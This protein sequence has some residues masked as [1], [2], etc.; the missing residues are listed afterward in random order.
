MSRTR[1]ATVIVLLVGGWMTAAHPRSAQ[2]QYSPPVT[3]NLPQVGGGPIGD[4]GRHIPE[5][6]PYGREIE[7]KQLK[8]LRQEHQRELKDDTARLLNLATALKAEVD[9]GTEPTTLPGDALKQAEEINK[10]A[11]KVSERIKTQ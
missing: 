3:T 8:R 5:N 11:K 4:A 7:E 2:A 9:K 6:E 10:L 1:L